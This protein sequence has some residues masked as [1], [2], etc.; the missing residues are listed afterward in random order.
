MTTPEGK[1]KS[2][3]DKMLKSEGVWYFSPQAGPYG[4]AG[5]PDRIAI[6]SGRFVGI[7]TKADEKKEMTALQSLCA[8]QIESAGGE[9]FLVRSYDDVEKVRSFIRASHTRDKISST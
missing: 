6:V 8:W 1:I 3:L 4:R 5:I 7:E 2:K 9:F